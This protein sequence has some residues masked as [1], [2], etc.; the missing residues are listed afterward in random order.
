MP[1]RIP[2]PGVPTP[3]VRTSKSAQP[4]AKPAAPKKAASPKPNPTFLSDGK[5]A[6]A[7]TAKTKGFKFGGGTE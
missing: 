5:G 1:N 7:G 2:T 3:T 6:Y 4:A